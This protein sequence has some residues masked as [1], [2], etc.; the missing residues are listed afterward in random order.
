MN[1]TYDLIFLDNLQECVH[2]A[3]ISDICF[4]LTVWLCTLYSMNF[5]NTIF[6][7]QIQFN[8]STSFHVVLCTV[9]S[10][11]VFS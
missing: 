10:S 4:A 8:I 7:Y 6:F 5:R 2:I 9:T 11:A 1:V 3:Y